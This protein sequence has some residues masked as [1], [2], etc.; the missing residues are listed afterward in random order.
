MTVYLKGKEG[1]A[2]QIEK[3]VKTVSTD[4]KYINVKYN[5]YT[6]GIVSGVTYYKD[7][8]EIVKIEA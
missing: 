8:V 7:E 5:T 6:W 2:D 1:R 4:D 3:N